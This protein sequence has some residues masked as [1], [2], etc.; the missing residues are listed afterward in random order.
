LS[1]RTEAVRTQLVDVGRRAKRPNVQVTITARN[2]AE[3]RWIYQQLRD[4][5]G[6]VRI[7]AQIER[8]S[9]PRI[10]LLTL[11]EPS[12]SRASANEEQSDVDGGESGG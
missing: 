11:P 10:D 1:A 4:A 6:D 8:G 9:P 5:P 7:Q 12:A 3:G 2:D